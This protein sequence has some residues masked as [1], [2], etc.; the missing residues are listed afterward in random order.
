MLVYTLPVTLNWLNQRP[1][2][3][4][5]EKSHSCLREY[6]MLH[7]YSMHL[8]SVIHCH[9]K[10]LCFVWQGRL[11]QTNRGVSSADFSPKRIV[12]APEICAKRCLHACSKNLWTDEHATENIIPSHESY[13]T[14][15]LGPTF[16]ITL[17]KSYVPVSLQRNFISGMKTKL[18]LLFRSIIAVYLQNRP[19]FVYLNVIKIQGLYLL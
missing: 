15:K 2:A 9:Y 4:P 19:K 18:L 7:R 13:Y 11:I 10:S 5:T 8:L 14:W 3:L 17:Y 1:V 6:N 12:H 16:P